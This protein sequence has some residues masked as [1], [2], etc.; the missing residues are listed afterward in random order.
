MSVL[1]KRIVIK[2]G[3]NVLTREANHFLD[4]EH[5]ASLCSLFTNLKKEGME[6]VIISSGA[7]TAGLPELRL[8]QYPKN[9]RIRQAAASVGQGKLI[10]LY[11]KE[12]RKDGFHAAQILLTQSDLQNRE[13]YINAKHTLESLVEYPVIPVLNENDCVTTKE[14]QLGDNDALSASVSALFNADLLIIFSNVDG[15]YDND[16][17]TSKE[18]RLISHISCFDD[19]IWNMASEAK[20]RW[21]LGGM[22]SKLS[23]AY[24]ATKKGCDVVILNGKQLEQSAAYLQSLFCAEKRCDV[25]QFTQNAPYGSFFEAQYDKLKSRAHW[26]FHLLPSRG[27]LRIDAGA[28]RAIT[29]K[30]RSLLPSGIISVEGDFIKGDALEICSQEGTLLAKG[31]SNYSAREIRSVQGKHS[32]EIAE[33]LG[34]DYGEEVIHRNDLVKAEEERN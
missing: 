7:V 27:K 32:S 31:L 4:H 5:I 6:L 8:E 9:I 20:S 15:L 1:Y 24:K 30:N 18:A 28:T 2:I 33:I 3:T 29:K 34:Y 11:N 22:K 12:F 25:L 23:A 14:L 13:R 10:S 17:E 26:I 19:K 21:G 16:P